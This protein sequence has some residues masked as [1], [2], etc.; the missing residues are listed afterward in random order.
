M[1]HKLQHGAGHR[2]DMVIE[3][4]MHGI[5]DAVDDIIQVGGKR[6]N[7]LGI[8]GRNEGRVETRVDLMKDA[9]GLL[10]E[11][12]NLMR[13][14]RKVGV[15]RGSPLDQQVGGL[16]DQ[17]HLLLEGLEELLITWKQVHVRTFIFSHAVRP[18]YDEFEA[19]PR[20]CKR[21]LPIPPTETA[22]KLL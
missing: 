6:L 13:G 12:V 17:F 9:V 19:V 14:I 1:R 8:E 16:T 15:S 4:P 20:L 5:L 21:R 3:H 10:F 22:T 7:V 11:H 2:I 18:A